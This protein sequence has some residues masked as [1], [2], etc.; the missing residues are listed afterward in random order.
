MLQVFEH[1]NA[2]ARESQSQGSTVAAAPLA[3]RGRGALKQSRVEIDSLFAPQ[4]G[5]MSEYRSAAPAPAQSYR[6]DAYWLVLE[7]TMNNFL[8]IVHLCSQQCK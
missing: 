1:G 4:D 7:L 3:P 8:T 6:H 5:L 2:N